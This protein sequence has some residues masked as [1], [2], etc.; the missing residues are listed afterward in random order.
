MLEIPRRQF[1]SL[2]TSF[3][4]APEAQQKLAGGGT[5]GIPVVISLRPGRGAGQVVVKRIFRGCKFHPAPLP[6][7]KVLAFLPVVAPP[8]NIHSPFRAKSDDCST[9]KCG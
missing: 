8:A 2:P 6:G 3:L 5:T 7:C 1:L 4:L 9:Q